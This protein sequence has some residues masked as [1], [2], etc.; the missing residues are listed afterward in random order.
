[1]KLFIEG[2]PKFTMNIIVLTISIIQGILLISIHFFGDMNYLDELNMFFQTGI[3]NPATCGP[4]LSIWFILGI[5]Y[6]TKK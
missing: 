1:M 3:P 5:L 6:L 4:L 2:R